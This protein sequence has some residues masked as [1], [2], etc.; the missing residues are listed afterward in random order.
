VIV[1]AGKV[2]STLARALAGGG[3]DVRLVPARALVRGRAPRSTFEAPSLVVLA[4]RD[5]DIDGVAAEI[6][7]RLRGAAPVAHTAGALGP[8]A[9]ARLVDLGVPV[10]QMH[11]LLSFASPPG[12][13]LAGATLLVSGHPRAVAAARRVAAATGM[14]ARRFPSLDPAL[15]HAAAA[16]L[17]NGAVAL[18]AAAAD[19]LG[20]GG[21]PARVAAAM[22][23]PLLAS[24]AQNVRRLGFPA[25]LSGPVRRGDAAT[26]ARHE[27]AIRR[28]NPAILPLYLASLEAQLGLARALGDAPRGDL[29]RVARWLR[30]LRAA[31]GAN[32]K[33]P[34]AAPRPSSEASSKPTSKRLKVPR[35]AR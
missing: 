1:G 15:Y 29:A 14:V 21:V 2:G 24:V 8:E 33:A 23:G 26:L 5:G 19:L 17:A 34:R 6:G 3:V 4:V 7:A 27:R 32:P 22:E 18:A 28:A 11:P 30:A 12:P 35:K 25:A 31:R 9:L 10:A 16:L 20:R 13:D